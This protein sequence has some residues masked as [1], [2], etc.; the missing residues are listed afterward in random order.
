MKSFYVFYLRNPGFGTSWKC[1]ISGSAG[2]WSRLGTYQ[3][4][5]GPDY[6]ENWKHIWIGSE[7]QIRLLE[8][9]Y[10]ERF[11]DKIIGGDAGYSEWITKT[12]EEELLEAVR[13][14]RE[15]YF[16]KCLDVPDEFKP[17]TADKIAELKAWA[18]TQK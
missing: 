8:E 5:F 13:F 15:E 11:A 14:F 7:K 10:K 17:F 9:K 16:I 4:A 1:G 6:K 2:L 3:N 18:E 12:N